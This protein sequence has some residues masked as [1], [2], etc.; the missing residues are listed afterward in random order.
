MD[1]DLSKLE[2]MMYDWMDQIKAILSEETWEN[3]LMNCSKNE[4]FV[5]MLLYRGAD[6]NMTQISDYLG[7]PLNTTTGIV[8][9]M[10]KKDMV[11]RL[12]SEADKRVVTIVLTEKGKDQIN[13]IIGVFLNY[14]QKVL[15]TLKPEEMALLTEVIG[16]VV[17]VLKES[18][19]TRQ[20]EK[21]KIRKIEIE[22]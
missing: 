9:R 17:K 10:E 6:V 16:K 1:F 8:S 4:L 20:S 13:D 21:P 15:A 5:L 19:M 2:S 7:S 11:R 3:I 14:A 22:I 18:P 12:R